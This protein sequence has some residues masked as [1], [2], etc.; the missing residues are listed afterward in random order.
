MTITYFTG[1]GSRKT[2]ADVFQRMQDICPTIAD[3]G[4]GLRTGGAKGA[5]SA[6]ELGYDHVG[7]VEIFLPWKGYNDH[8]SYRY[9]I[10]ESAF[11]LAEELY[12]H[13]WKKVSSGVKKLMARNCQQVLGQNLDD[14][15]IFVLCWTKD[16][17]ESHSARRTKTGG[18]GQ[19]I[20]VASTFDIP[21]I[22]M[23][24]KGWEQRLSQLLMEIT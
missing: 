5:D 17:C 12:I 3:R 14:P 11:V 23:Y 8:P 13:N 18:T 7:P 2:P 6:F 9:E 24:N 19:A 22:N 10:P 21:V 20:S 1:V 4:V 15:S 16:G